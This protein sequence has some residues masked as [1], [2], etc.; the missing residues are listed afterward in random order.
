M[1]YSSNISSSVRIIRDQH[2]H[3]YDGLTIL[4]VISGTIRVR[5]LARET[6][7]RE[8]DIV[9]FNNG[10]IRKIRAL[11]EEN[12]VIQINFSI[13][14]CR[15]AYISYDDSFVICNSVRFEQDHYI[16][17]ELLRS[18]FKLFLKRIG[19]ASDYRTDESVCKTGSALIV[20]LCD[21][22]D[23]ISRGYNLKQFSEDVIKRNRWLYQNILNITGEEHSFSLK[24]IS[25]ILGVSYSYYRKDILER[26]G[27]GYK[28]LKYL[29]MTESAARML[30]NTTYSATVIG[31]HCGFSDYKYMSKYFNILYGYTPSEFRKVYLKVQVCNEKQFIDIPISSMLHFSKCFYD[32]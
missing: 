7:L 2:Y 3:W 19:S 31:F 24:K 15:H 20:Y 18:K 21:E 27:A 5:I 8:G 22:F 30:I 6:N 32:T 26:Y 12:L 28:Y 1:A 17:Y 23:Y 29:V 10:S 25:E 14:F 16:K 11:T 4:M 9:V 13:D